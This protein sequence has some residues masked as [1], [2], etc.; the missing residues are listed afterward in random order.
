MNEW[1]L[2]HGEW[3]SIMRLVGVGVGVGSSLLVTTHRPEQEIFIPEGESGIE[4]VTCRTQI[5]SGLE[6]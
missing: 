3:G 4:R 2:Y 1:T 5:F 6:L